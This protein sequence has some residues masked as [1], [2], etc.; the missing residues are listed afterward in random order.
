MTTP[1]IWPYRLAM[2]VIWVGLVIF[3]TTVGYIVWPSR[4]I[5]VSEP[6][7]IENKNKQVEAGD[8][9]YLVMAYNKPFDNETFIGVMV[10]SRGT[11]WLLPVTLAALPPNS[12]DE[13]GH[14]IRIPVPIPHE[15]TPGQY[16]A[17]LSIV[18]PVRL[19]LPTLFHNAVRAHSE[20]F[21]V[22][23]AKTP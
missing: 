14:V 22:V 10:A 12:E 5:Y 6:I 8:I 21:T 1:V 23:A 17:V 3:L 16:V 13:R 4:P 7:P 18:H 15:V 2:A 11:I 9:L 20:P 19:P